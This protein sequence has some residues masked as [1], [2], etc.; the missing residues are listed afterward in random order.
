[1]NAPEVWEMKDWSL[2]LAEFLV[3]YDKVYGLALQGSHITSNVVATK[4]FAY[5]PAGGDSSWRMDVRSWA[6][7][8]VHRTSKRYLKLYWSTTTVMAWRREMQTKPLLTHSAKRYST[9]WAEM[10]EIATRLA[11]ISD[12]KSVEFLILTSA[13][14]VYINWP[15]SPIGKS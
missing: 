1:M 2:G 6:I 9:C 5:P 11:E 15:S 7:L 4:C 13:W 14:A 12:V 3:L 8:H 10:H